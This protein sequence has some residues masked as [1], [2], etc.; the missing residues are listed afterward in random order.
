MTD[1]AFPLH[2]VYLGLGGLVTLGF[3]VAYLVRT[4]RMARMV[5]IGLPSASARADYRAIYGGSQI[6]IGGFF[7]LAA[8]EPEW[9][10][11]ALLA[12]GMFAAGFGVVRV[13]SLAIDRGGRDV[14]WIVGVLEVIAGV[15]ALWLMRGLP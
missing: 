13:G 14:Q 9:H 2:A 7:L 10:Q 12:L 6:A 15:I 5:G 4:S 3:G 1:F 11:S 8:R